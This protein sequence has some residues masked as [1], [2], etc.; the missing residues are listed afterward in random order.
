MVRLR[1]CEPGHLSFAMYF[2]GFFV[3]VFF[4]VVVFRDKV[5]LVALAVLE[6]TM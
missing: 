6:L 2:V 4:F 5:S 1:V 3:F